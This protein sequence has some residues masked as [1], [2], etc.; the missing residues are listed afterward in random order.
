MGRVCRRHSGRAKKSV[1]RFG[2]NGFEGCSVVLLGVKCAVEHAG[3][4]R[5]SL[6]VRR[7]WANGQ[8]AQLASRGE[9]RVA[10]ARGEVGDGAVK[11]R[12]WRMKL[13]LRE[14][15]VN[16][17]RAEQDIDELRLGAFW[18]VNGDRVNVWLRLAFEDGDVV[19]FI[20]IGDFG[21]DVFAADAD[22]DGIRAGEPVCGCEVVLMLGGDCFGRGLTFAEWRGGFG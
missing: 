15:F 8:G 20:A 4:C 3:M 6:C 22:V 12:G 19:G 18:R 2:R 7:I 14:R 13:M 5:K 21:G 17:A 9:N 1:I 11:M 10:V 16:C